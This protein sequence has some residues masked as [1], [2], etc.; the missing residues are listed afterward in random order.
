MVFNRCCLVAA[1]RCIVLLIL[2]VSSLNGIAQA[3][4]ITGVITNTEGLTVSGVSV[5]LKGGNRGTVSDQDG[6]YQLTVPDGSG[7]LEFSSVGYKSQV[8]QINNR[9]AINVLLQPDSSNMNEVVV[10]GYTATLRKDLTSAI[11]TVNMEELQKAPVPSFEQALAGR[12]AGVQVSSQSGRPGSG[13]DI[14]IRGVSSISQ[15]NAPLFVID[16][17][18]I[19]SPDNNMID[20]QNIESISVLKD[21][22]ATA[23]YGAKGSN[24][25]IVITTK[26]GV[27]GLPKITYNGSYGVSEVLKYMK[28]LNAFEFVQL[29][30]DVSTYNN[31]GNAFLSGGKVLEDYRHV[32]GV[33][34]QKELFR[35]GAQ[36]NH[37]LSLTGGTNG[38]LYSISGNYFTQDGVMIGSSFRRYQGK[39]S[40]EQQVGKRLKVGGTVTYTNNLIKGTDPQSGQVNAVFYNVYSYPPIS[41]V[42]SEQLLGLIQDPDG[43][44][45]DYRINPL[46]NLKNQVRNN[47][48]NNIITNLFLDYKIAPFLKLTLRGS[49]NNRF[50]RADQFN[51]P[52]TQAGVQIPSNTNGIN[53]SV[54]N[55]RYDY[56]N[57]TNLLTF[58]K[59][60]NKLHRVNIVLGTDIQRVESRGAG[61][62]GIQ[63]STDLLG[64]SGIDAGQVR[65]PPVASVSYNTMASGIVSGAYNYG[66]KY[67]LTFNFRT[68][69]SSKFVGAN[70]WGYFPSGAVKWKFTNEKFIPKNKI[71]SDGNIRFSYGT[72]GNNR[73]SD[74]ATYSQISVTGGPLSLNGSNQPSSILQTTLS[75]PDLKWEVNKQMDLGLDLGFFENKLNLTVD[76]YNRRTDNLLY[77]TLLPPNMGFTSSIVNIASISNRGLE[78]TL[79]AQLIKTAQFSYSS[80]FNISFNRN[81]LNKLSDPTQDGI[82]STINWDAN[83]SPI[84]AYIAKI[85]GPLGQI[86]GLVS[87]GLYQYSDFDR[88]PNGSYVLKPG[89]ARN[90]LGS[91]A[92]G[93]MKFVDINHDGII[94][95]NDQTII[96]NGYPGNYGGWSNN[97]RWKNFDLNLF[98]QWSYGT[99]VINANRMWFSTGLGIQNRGSIMPYQNVFR[100]FM[101]RW[102]PTNQ[103]T[104]IPALGQATNKYYVSQ[105]VEDASFV[106]LKTVNLGYSLP[107]KML[108]RYK[109]SNLRIYIATNNIFT[110]T[111][112]KGYDPEVSAFSSALTPGFD[113][114]TYPRPFTA[115]AGID[116]SF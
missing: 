27:R 102:S 16:G 107:Q 77:Q 41:T 55:Y 60:F 54:V 6:R 45:T 44:L 85:G 51:G 99:N 90:T 5:Q 35:T 84:P 95:E 105:F 91:A 15:A 1:G 83:Y 115:V 110:L 34:W 10:T 8:Q 113:Y 74:F 81:R 93:G 56:Y 106:R 30:A 32:Q 40:L 12:V 65:L 86:Y 73:V 28:L 57:N 63:L 52:N 36:Q 94:N 89:V 37:S 100:E 31:Q 76:L 49:A 92:P 79:N 82:T 17:F 69:G 97:L 4:K 108:S 47:I 24:G 38:T 22:S 62:T 104:D 87:D 59:T 13:I 23:L 21:A 9:N 25:V 11:G 75:N 112:Y 48:S 67:Y 53:G 33:D 61:Y 70:R 98:F 42:G 71:L 68:D 19:E 64:V 20:P 50:V 18:A 72:T 109:I 26:K 111:G 39:I 7:V 101:D 46:L 43:S 96:G 78:V 103:D 66:S 116:L 114:S 80:N 88:M 2:I 58:D 29:Q 14:I 3:Q